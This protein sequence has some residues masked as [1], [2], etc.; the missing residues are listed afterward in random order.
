MGEGG[1][2][3]GKGGGEVGAGRRGEEAKQ[4]SKVWRGVKVKEGKHRLLVARSRA[5]VMR[6]QATC[7]VTQP[8]VLERT[9]PIKVSHGGR[10]CDH[11][12][13]LLKVSALS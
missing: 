1:K 5:F 7:A 6:F 13:S 8:G 9:T 2:K 3:R 11:P 4:R 10:Q 12:Y